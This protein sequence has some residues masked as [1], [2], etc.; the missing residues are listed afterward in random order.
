MFVDVLFKS[1]KKH[2]DEDDDLHFSSFSVPKFDAEAE[3][4]Q[5][6]D[7]VVGEVQVS[8][9]RERIHAHPGEH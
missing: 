9:G 3:R 6:G 1:A 8:D 4:L 7:S 2:G 5:E